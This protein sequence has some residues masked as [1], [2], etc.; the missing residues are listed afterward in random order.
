MQ[1]TDRKIKEIAD[2]I[3]KLSASTDQKIKQVTTQIGKLGGRLGEF[4]EGLVRPGCIAM[5]RERGLPVD[6][7]FSRLSKVRDGEE[8][9]IDLLVADT[10]VA[11]PIEVKSHLT[12][13]DVRN[14]LKRLDKFKHFFP[15]FADCRIH[16]AVAGM[17]ISAEADRFA[18][19]QGLFVIVQSGDSVELANGPEFQPKSW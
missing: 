18:M 10:V 14:H 8:M 16:G 5:F 15:R 7:V 11:I 12:V 13:E 4:V 9:E 2:Q 17:V 3:Q 1:E 19:N 6:E